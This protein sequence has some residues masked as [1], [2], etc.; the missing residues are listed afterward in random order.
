MAFSAES[1]VS[2]V[3]MV[4]A[5]LIACSL[6]LATSVS[7]QQVLDFYTVQSNPTI[8]IARGVERFKDEVNAESGGALEVRVH[9]AGT[10]QIDTTDITGA[11]AANVVEL[12]DDLF[13][14]GNVPLGAVLRLPF[15]I[16]GPENV[17]KAQAATHGDVNAAFA[18]QGVT[19]LCGYVAPPQYVWGRDVI[20]SMDDIK[21]KKIRVSSPEQAEFIKRIGGVPLTIPAAEVTTSLQRGVVDGILTAG[22]GGVMFG[23]NLASGFMLPVNYNNG[24]FIA[25]TDT[26]EALTPEQQSLLRTVAERNCKWI[27]D[28]FFED[29]EK[30]IADFKANG[31]PIAYPT[32]EELARSSQ[33][34][35][36]YWDDWAN[37]NGEAGAKLLN[38]VK[39]AVGR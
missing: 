5:G 32:E 9:L 13:F 34:I 38:A 30:A 31:F 3:S 37:K 21:G 12:G 26:F 17:E 1:R 6:A 15:L 24:Y 4:M 19:A 16:G 39:S 33:A 36:D 20:A 10:L 28:T 22:F 35:V 11:V 29:D 8:A 23:E 14:S 27:Q 25:N 18:E 2:C 7:A